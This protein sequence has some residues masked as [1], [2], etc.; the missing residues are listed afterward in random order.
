M[1]AAHEAQVC[2]NNQLDDAEYDP[3][4]DGDDESL[5]WSSCESLSVSGSNTPPGLDTPHTEQ[6]SPEVRKLSMITTKRNYTPGL[7]SL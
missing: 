1:P 5:S 4:D 2:A 6:C 7:T 3:M